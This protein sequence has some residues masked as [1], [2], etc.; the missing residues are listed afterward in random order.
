MK[1]PFKKIL[2]GFAFSPS[3]GAN[4]AEAVRLSQFFEAELHLVHVGEK[5]SAKEQEL[6][7]LLQEQKIVQSPNIHVFWKEGKRSC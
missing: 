6:E 2:F 5:T 3:L 4:L 1:Q 7:R